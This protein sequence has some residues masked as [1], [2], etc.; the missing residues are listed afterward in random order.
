MKTFTKLLSALL[1]GTASM[2]TMNAQS[3]MFD[4]PDNHAY[5]GVRA[6]LDISS[7]ANG[8]AYFCNKA[9]FSVGLVYNIPI[10]ANLYFEPGLHL[11]Y[12]TFG[13][14]HIEDASY[15]KVNEATGEVT[16]VPRYYQVN[17]TLRNF[18]FRIPL[19]IG[20]HFDFSDELSVAVYTGPQLNIN[21]VARYHQNSVITPDN[22]HVSAGS[23]NAFGTNGFNHFDLQWNFGVG[24]NYQQYYVGLGGAVGVTHMMSAATIA[25]GP[26]AVSFPRDIRR[27]LFNITLGYNF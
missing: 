11:F 8:E 23:V 25:V 22:E 18:G 4:N 1:I 13:T 16:T 10:V 7:A 14:T 6:G 27:N 21:Y 5:F 17:G 24:L 12:N 2:M 19:N 20:Y 15:D 9:G 3:Y 26:Y